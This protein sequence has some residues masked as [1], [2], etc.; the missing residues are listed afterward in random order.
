MRTIRRLYF[1]AVTLVSLEVV[2]WGLIGLARSAFSAQVVGG[3]AARLAQALALILV[4]VPFFGLHWWIAQRD[5]RAEMEEHASGLRAFF[6]YAALLVTLIPIV[7][8]GLALLNRILLQAFRLPQTA[9]FGASQSWSDNV[10]A[11][12]MNALVAAYFITVLRADWKSVTPRDTLIILRRIYRYIWVI[13]ALVML[14]AGVQQSLQYALEIPA[15]TIGSA[16]NASFA[17]GVTLLL[18]GAPLWFFAWRT[19]QEAL[20]GDAERES[21]LR[22]AV[23]YVLSLA[24]VI[25][26]MTS[27]GVVLAILLRR[28]LGES[29][30]IPNVLRQIGGPLSIGIPLAGVWVYYGRWLG[31]ALAEVQEAP[32]RA[33][34]R[35]LYYYI[36][37][38]LGL[39]AT[40]T[41]LAML[42]SFIIGISIGDL[43]WAG[44]LRPRLAASLATLCASLPLW[45]LTWRPMQTEAL[46]PGDR[47]DHARRSLVR[48]AYLYLALFASVIGGMV[49]AVALLFLLIRALLGDQPPAFIQNLLNNVQLLFLF[50]GMGLYHGLMLR[51]DGQL[52]ASALSAKHALFP[53]LIF[54]D[55]ENDPFAVTMLAAL[56][57]VAPQLP[58]AIQPFRQPVAENMLVSTKVTILPGD[59]V[60]NP[61]E[62]LRLWLRDFNGSRIIVPRDV[63]GWIWAG[64]AGRSLQSTT[65]Q[66]AQAVRQLAEGQEFHKQGGI[67]GWQ[68]VV[69]IAAGL[70]GLEI[71]MALIGMG[72][73][74]FQR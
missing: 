36:L 15:I 55:S 48:K 43:L 5:S 67:S 49:S 52:A 57:K 32:R 20:T 44:T 65:I 13:Y 38:A 4:G 73:S 28:L 72:V 31:C 51:R 12:L 27:G 8:N 9:M 24:G 59:L 69:I 19:V 14:V 58:A 25:T 33:G 1:Y 63:E 39:G 41:G 66:A 64:G 50:T 42:L 29:M 7:Q 16:H 45:L 21:T 70:F 40:F 22:L 71:M 47:G 18:M 60:L 46:T 56:H 37:S 11:M 6:L 54:A 35:R 74:L 26:V 62:S 53:V 3:G 30:N 10:I 68:I 61:N 34:M 17:N 23:L 2:L